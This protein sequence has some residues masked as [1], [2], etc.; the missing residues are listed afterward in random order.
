M[1]PAHRV[2][3]G[4]WEVEHACRGIS[5]GSG[6]HAKPTYSCIKLQGGDPEGPQEARGP[7][8]F[9]SISQAGQG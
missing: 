8:S 2:L 9:P 3:L 1:L 7:Q 6:G 4:G 5:E